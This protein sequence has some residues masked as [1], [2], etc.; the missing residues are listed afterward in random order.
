MFTQIFDGL[1]SYYARYPSRRAACG[2]H[3]A[4]TMSF[5]LSV[6][7]TGAVVPGD[8]LINGSI[9]RSVTLLG[10]KAA[11]ILAGVIIG[12]AHVYFAKRTGHY[13]STAPLPAPHWRAYVSTPVLT[14]TWRKVKTVR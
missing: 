1:R 11:L 6:A 4:A 7:L 10:K 5:I 12:C 3:A 13:H 9:D 2:F 8:Y 14:S